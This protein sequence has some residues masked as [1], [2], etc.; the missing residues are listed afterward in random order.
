MR[1]HMTNSSSTWK[2]LFTAL[3]ILIFSVLPAT[4]KDPARI[5]EGR[6]VKVSDGDTIQVITADGTKLK[7][8]LYGID[9]PETP[10]M[11]HRGGKVN[12]PGQPYG[13]EAERALA[14]KIAGKSVRLEIMDIDQYKRMVSRI[15]LDGRDINREMV[16]EGRAW[17]Y[18]Q[19]LQSPYA[20]EYIGAE[21]QARAARL[22]LWQQSN[23]QPPWEFR[24][25][26]KIR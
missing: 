12:K 25:A 8:R 20:S 17:A 2:I 4:A 26:L 5:V 11:N 1:K 16:R 10:K 18:K 7:S 19:Y 21:K 15:I 6:V 9:A 23:P 24:K 13:E 22:G 3:F 14:Q